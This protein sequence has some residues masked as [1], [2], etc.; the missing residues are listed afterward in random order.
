MFQPPRVGHTASQRRTPGDWRLFVE[1]WSASAR[2]RG[3]APPNP[4]PDRAGRI[5][6]TCARVMDRAVVLVRRIL[7]LAVSNEQRNYVNC[8]R[9]S[10]AQTMRTP[11]VLEPADA[12]F[13]RPR[14]RVSCPQAR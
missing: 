10:Q 9:N 13:S 11:K 1:G 6:K 7:Y 3:E 5:A 2:S 4:V 12:V 14:M 8:P